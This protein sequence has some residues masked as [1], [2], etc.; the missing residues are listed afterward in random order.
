[1]IL[2]YLKIS[3]RNLRKNK[4]YSFINIAGLSV[5]LACALAIG[6]FIGDEVSFDRF[7]KNAKNIYRVVQTQ[8]Q[9][10]NTYRVAVSPGG[11][12]AALKNDFPEVVASCNVGYPRTNTLKFGNTVVEVPKITTADPGFFK[13]FDFELLAGNPE[14]LFT[15]PDQIVLSDRTAVALFGNTEKAVGSIVSF[16]KDL[17]L[18]VTGIVKA[19]PVNS[20]IQ[21]DAIRSYD[22]AD[23]N[24]RWNSNSYHTYVLLSDEADPAAMNARLHDYILKYRDPNSTFA[25]PVFYLQPLTDIYL[26]SDFDFETDWAKTSN[27]VYVR[28]FAAVGI[29]VLVIAVFNFVNLSTAR[30]IRRAKEVGIR[31]SIGAV[32]RQLMIQFLGES[33]LITSISVAVAIVLTMLGMPFLNEVAEKTLTI[34]FGEPAF[35][36]AVLSFTLVV[37]LLAGIYPAAY[38]SSFQPA[39]VL[40]GV[41]D[42]RSGRRFRQVL[43]V[44]QFTLTVVL[45]AGAIVIY[46]QLEFLREKNLGFDKSQLIYVKTKGLSVQNKKLFRQDLEGQSSV[47]AASL[48][49]NSLIDVTNST[50]SIEWEGQTAGDKF[51]MTQLNV[52]PS[53]LAT[54]GIALIAGK[55]FNGSVVDQDSYLINETAAKRMGWTNEEAVG[56]SFKIWDMPGQIIGVVKDFHF[57]PMTA[58]IE[59]ILFMC[60]A[61]PWYQGVLVKANPG[62]VKQAIA[63]IEG[64]YKKFDPETAATYNFVD[65]ELDKQYHFEQRAGNIVLFFSVLAIVVACLG[66]YGLATF[67][68]ERRTKEIAIRKVLGATVLNVSALLSKDFILLV[69]ISNV[70]AMPVG[71]LLTSRW[72]ESFVYR[73]DADW[74]FLLA[75]GACA[76]IIALITI[77]FQAVSAASTNTVK[78]LRSE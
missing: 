34:P 41:F 48:A 47:A 39:K 27:I 51:I 2:N 13:I 11:M 61:A 66:L 69:L 38:L 72:L 50:V 16:N 44:I 15:A 33:L 67:T 65:Q 10:G 71:Y 1:M 30:A 26:H 70:I 17:P 37:S 68:T 35:I 32:Y 8:V 14:K 55:N 78:S 18:I 4:A 62:Q 31:K 73:I 7:H 64:S 75:A 19:P 12:A 5:G 54:T 9:A 22:P 6:L 53:Y 29:V 77:S 3:W 23:P 63:S 49:S 24:N 76:L 45:V 42:I 60:K 36:V 56:K 46:K 40:K 21:F 28:V 74:K 25:P 20:H 59:P 52:E 43:V 57:R 58:A